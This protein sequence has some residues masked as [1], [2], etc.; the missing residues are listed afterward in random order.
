[1]SPTLS[2]VSGHALTAAP[3]PPRA[4]ERE[5]SEPRKALSP[6]GPLA[7][8][9]LCALAMTVV[10]ALAELVPAIHLKDATALYDFTTLNRPR[11]ESVASFLLRLL[12]P[13]AFALWGVAL[14]A[15]ALAYRRPRVAIA[16]VVVLALAPVSADLLKP[17]LAHPHDHVRGVSIGA[18]SW[19]SGHATAATALALCAVLV[20]PRRLRPVVAVFGAVFV[21]AIAVS[22]LVLAWHM[23]SDVIGGMLLASLWMS[24]A[25]A[26]LRAFER[27]R[28]SRRYRAPRE[29]RSS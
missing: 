27:V 8:A 2:G 11:V 9:G 5:R 23:P 29:P 16:A 26:A 7:V 25:V 28:P 3:R 17:L 21:A 22:L 12:E 6:L 15:V 14:V 19:P 13:G 20:A 10:W 4:L 18:S 24:L 1:M